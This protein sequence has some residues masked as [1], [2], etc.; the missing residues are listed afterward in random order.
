[1]GYTCG[2]SVVCLAGRLDLSVR[3]TH[4][5]LPQKH[6][7]KS[8]ITPI[9]TCSVTARSGAA[10]TVIRGLSDRWPVHIG[11]LRAGAAGKERVESRVCRNSPDG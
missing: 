9:Y 10:A 4:Q 8:L 2:T 11:R 3:N 1:M 5:L 7:S 6:E